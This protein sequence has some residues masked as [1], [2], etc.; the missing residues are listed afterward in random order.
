MKNALIGLG[1]LALVL[2]VIRPLLKMLKVEKQVTFMPLQDEVENTQLL[3]AQRREQERLR[4][5]QLDLV[6]KVK[7]DPYQAAQILQNWLTR[8]E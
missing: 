8:K 4:L 7:A 5:T 6:E 3:E 2:F 1:F